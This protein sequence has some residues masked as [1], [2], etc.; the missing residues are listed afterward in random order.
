[1]A[2]L[3]AFS[4]QEAIMSQL[5]FLD[6][7]ER[8]HDKDNEAPQQITELHIVRP[9]L[10]NV[11]LGSAEW[12]EDKEEESLYTTAATL[13][14]PVTRSP[15]KS[16]PKIDGT[17]TEPVVKGKKRDFGN[18]IEEISKTKLARHTSK[19]W[20]FLRNDPQPIQSVPHCR[21][22]P[23]DDDLISFENDPDEIKGEPIEASLPLIGQVPVLNAEDVH[24]DAAPIPEEVET[25]KC[26]TC[27]LS[28]AKSLI[29]CPCDH[30]YCA[31]CLCGMVKS[32]LRD[33]IPFP[34]ACCEK[35]ITIDVNAGFFDKN[36]LCDFFARKFG[37][38]YITP[39][40]KKIPPQVHGVDLG[41]SKN[42]GLCYLCKR[43]N[44]KDSFCPDCCYRCN[45]NRTSCPCAANGNAFDPKAPVFRPTNNSNKSGKRDST[46]LERAG[47]AV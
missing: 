39:S 20:S 1:M 31:E 17:S 37:I 35:P 9:Y 12:D 13:A 33:D 41:T 26:F 27:G 28:S 16:W 40:P 29:M 34:P 30:K 25:V 19:A 15:G 23:D 47:R 10:K 44:E 4:A 38:A 14:E 7:W 43:V 18:R 32:S 5:I 36:T 11:S 42:E 22:G 21:I 3:T 6:G 45:R 2:D 24:V 8:S 46:L